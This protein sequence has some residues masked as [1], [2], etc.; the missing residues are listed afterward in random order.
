LVGKSGD[1]SSNDSIQNGQN[2]HVTNWATQSKVA[3]A[4]AAGAHSDGTVVE[5][6]IDLSNQNFL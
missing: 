4:A 5:D 1:E 3:N 6:D 2:D